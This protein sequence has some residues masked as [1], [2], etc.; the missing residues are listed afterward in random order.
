[1]PITANTL[2]RD[3]FNFL[4]NQVPAIILLALLTAFVTVM[5][6]KAFIPDSDQLSILSAA[7][8]N[9]TSS[10]SISEMVSQMT[11]EQQIVLLKVSAVVT[12]SALVGNVLL[13]GGMLTLISMVSQGRRVSA[14]QAIGLSLP[15]LPRLLLLMFIG[16]LVIQLGLTFFIVPG[17]V[18]AV[19]LSLSPMIVTNER[20]GIFAAMKASAQ[21]AFANIRLIVPAMMLWIA[22]K[23]LLLFL[24]SRLAILPPEIATVIF[25]TLSNLASAL[26]LV[27]LFRLY[28]LLRTVSLDKY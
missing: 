22:T 21:L 9:I 17:V 20:I 6:N 12:F 11:Q 28:M 10:G 1:M 15:I 7:E 24:V 27:Y 25:G 23:L 2:Y 8:N 3:S 26:L 19:A 18:I 13:V 14:L 16:T 4:R 5:L